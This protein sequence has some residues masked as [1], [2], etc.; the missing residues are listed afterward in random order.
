[1]NVCVNISPH[2][3]IRKPSS[4]RE[5]YVLIY[6]SESYSLLIYKSESYCVAILIFLHE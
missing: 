4:V 3:G 2:T 6:K 5:P 1:M